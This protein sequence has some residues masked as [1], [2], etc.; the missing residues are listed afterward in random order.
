[1]QKWRIGDVTVTK[2]VELEATG[3]TRFILPQATPDAVLGMHWMKPH[4]M[5]DNGKLKMSIHALVIE[6]PGRAAMR[7]APDAM[8]REVL[9]AGTR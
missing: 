4:F 7:A 9:A 6:A 1:M 3:G 2:I 8:V 5:D